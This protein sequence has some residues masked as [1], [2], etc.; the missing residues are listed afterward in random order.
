MN[1]PGSGRQLT[2]SLGDLTRAGSLATAWLPSIAAGISPRPGHR[3]CSTTFVQTA[4]SVAIL[5]RL[6]KT[7]PEIVALLGGAN[8]EG[9]I[10]DGLATLVPE[11][12]YISQETV[13]RHSPSSCEN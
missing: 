11:V 10:S 7:G 3:G 1:R 6:K 12:D 13:R 2:V 8:C 9:V 4:A 5:R